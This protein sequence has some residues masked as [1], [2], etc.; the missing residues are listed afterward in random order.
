VIQIDSSCDCANRSKRVIPDNYALALHG[1]AG[2]VAGRDYSVV[3]DHMRQLT[4]ECQVQLAAGGSALDVVEFAVAAME[5]SGLCVAGRG[6]APNTAGYVELDASIMDGK[7]RAAGAV[8]AIV[9][10]VNPVS[11]A[12]CIMQ[13]T[14]HVMLTGKGA[15]AFARRLNLEEVGDPDTYYILPVGVYE[16]EI[17][18]QKHGTVGAVALDQSG[19]VAAAT[20][21][22]GTFGKLEGR[23]GDSPMIGAG[24][25]ADDDIAISFTGTGEHIIRSGGAI[26]IAHKVKAGAT[27]EIA[28]DEVLA[29]IR[30]LGGDAGVIAV[31]CDGEIAMAYNSDGMKRASVSSKEPLRV[32]TFE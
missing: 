9:G 30:R 7:T 27:V 8:A 23:V 4:E 11:V 20:S 12:R 14:P 18:E 31:T 15:L 25:W 16:D 26:S 10:V 19:G 22:G 29:E 1:G 17:Y 3:E 2:P 28:I 5:S 6:S 21:T 13:E 24:T 32:A